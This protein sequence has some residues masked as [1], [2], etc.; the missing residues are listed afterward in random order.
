MRRRKNNDRTAIQL[1]GY[2]DEEW[3]RLIDWRDN[4][5]INSDK[6]KA[7]RIKGQRI[8]RLKI[9]Q[10]PELVLADEILDDKIH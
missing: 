2:S 6:L 5:G 9:E 1:A 3:G 7:L 8:I 10:S 4:K